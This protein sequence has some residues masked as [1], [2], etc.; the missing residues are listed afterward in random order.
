MTFSPSLFNVFNST[1]SVT[2]SLLEQIFLLA[3][4]SRL[5]FK[6]PEITT[7]VQIKVILNWRLLLLNLRQFS[8][9]KI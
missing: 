5:T 1:I 7:E 6:I 3:S 2:T 4:S 9:L 8:T